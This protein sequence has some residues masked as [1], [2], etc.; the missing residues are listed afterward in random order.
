MKK[1]MINTTY[2]LVYTNNPLNNN[3]STIDRKG[4]YIK[5]QDLKFHSTN[6]QKWELV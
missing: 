1:E 4:I 3:N 6:I 5:K 2:Y